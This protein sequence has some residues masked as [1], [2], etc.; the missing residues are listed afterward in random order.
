MSICSTS[1]QQHTLSSH[2]MCPLDLL[3]YAQERMR[4][5]KA[6]N[7]FVITKNSFASVHLWKGSQGPPT[8]GSQDY[9]FIMLI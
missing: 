8:L 5:K 6:D 2:T 9:T 1:F 3:L 4:A 7:T